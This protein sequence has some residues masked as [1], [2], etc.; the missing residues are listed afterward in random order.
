MMPDAK[1]LP[2]KS[3]D[4]E[5]AVEVPL[6]MIYLG[7][8]KLASL[9]ESGDFGDIRS[10]LFFLSFLASEGHLG[11]GGSCAIIFDWYQVLIPGYFWKVSC[12]Q[13]LDRPTC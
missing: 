10:S 9:V 8:T 7:R 5:E 2:T 13:T 12:V 3:N 6:R 4:A 11:G 1:G